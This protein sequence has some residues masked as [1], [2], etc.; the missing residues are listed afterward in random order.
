MDE[1]R[2]RQRKMDGEIERKIYGDIGRDMKRYEEI[3]RD[4]KGQE[5]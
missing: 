5:E 3:R 4:R 1:D 2:G